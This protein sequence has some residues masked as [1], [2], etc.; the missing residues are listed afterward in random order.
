MHPNDSTNRFSD[1]AA[2]YDLYRPG[3]PTA[4][5]TYLQQTT[6]LPA[7]SIIAD[8]GSGTGIFSALLLDAGYA[9]KAV[10]PNQAM[11]MAAEKKLQRCTF[12]ESIT[13]SAEQ[14]QLPDHA[15]DLITVAQAFHWFNPAMVKRECRRILKPGGYI[16]LAWNILQS[17]T[18]VLK[19]Y[20]GIKEKYAAGSTPTSQAEPTLINDFFAPN[21]VATRRIRHIKW[22]DAAGIK[23][24][25]L[26][27]SKIPL[28][29]NS[30]YTAMLRELAGL[31]HQYAKN[32]VLKLEYETL[33]FLAQLDK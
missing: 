9:V 5:I 14:T 25:L 6:G 24:L 2:N 31:H 18:P 1:R 28:H 16:L 20:T 30:V 26:S 33:L 19:A 8:I 22:L 15:V 32:G 12:F 17:D 4:V 27:S 11:R 29:Q 21:P 3:Y 23:G 13:G 10:E 7:G